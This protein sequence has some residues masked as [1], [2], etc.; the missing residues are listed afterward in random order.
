[1]RAKKRMKVARGC[2][3]GTI[4]RREGVRKMLVAALVVLGVVM[5]LLAGVPFTTKLG[6]TYTNGIYAL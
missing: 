6:K 3:A 4:K 1:M 2:F 5:L